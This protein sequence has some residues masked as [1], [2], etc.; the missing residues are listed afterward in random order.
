MLAFVS[1]SENNTYFLKHM[2]LKR[3]MR[4]RFFFKM[5]LD[6]LFHFQLLI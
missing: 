5:S 4:M 1:F 3:K 6:F 2:K